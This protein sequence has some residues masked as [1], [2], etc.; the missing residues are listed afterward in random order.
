MD[1]DNHPA[2]QPAAT[3][4]TRIWLRRLAI[5]AACGPLALVS[6]LHT[7]G[8]TG[9]FGVLG[10]WYVLVPLTVAGLF[11]WG[12]IERAVAISK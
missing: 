4:R 10:E 5:A 6:V 12:L 9:D 7:M 3:S 2:P 1:I 11:A 8:R